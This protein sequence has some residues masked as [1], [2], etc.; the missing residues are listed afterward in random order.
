[1]HVEDARPR[2]RIHGHEQRAVDAAEGLAGVVD[3]R[4]VEIGLAVTVHVHAVANGADELH[5]VGHGLAQ[6]VA[7]ADEREWS[8]H[9]RGHAPRAADASV[10][11][12]VETAPARWQDHRPPAA[13]LGGERA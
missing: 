6:A 8:A 5:Q 2:E 13:L 1:G 4:A 10:A 7:A 9:R 11:V 3:A 12:Q